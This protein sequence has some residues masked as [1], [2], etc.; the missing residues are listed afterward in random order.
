MAVHPPRIPSYRLHKPSGQARVIIGG[1]HRY[2]GKY[3][4]PESLEK[5]HRLV[6]EHVGTPASAGHR[7]V[8]GA[9]E[10]S[11]SIDELILAYW[12][13]ARNYYVRNGKP[14][15]RLYHVRLAMRP[16]RKLYGHT[17]ANEFG[18]QKLKTVREEMTTDGLSKGRGLNRGYINDHTGICGYDKTDVPREGYDP[19]EAFARHSNTCFI[20]QPPVR[21]GR[22][23]PRRT[24]LPRRGLRPGLRSG[25]RQSAWPM[26]CAPGGNYAASR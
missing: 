19:T 8:A 2:L 22:L 9:R 6:A 11:L 7:S 17:P 21:F 5:Y 10:P 12:R 14:T 20:G 24:W 13:H 15:D 1:E 23:S 18:P 25:R 16:L 26:A 4:S 3:G